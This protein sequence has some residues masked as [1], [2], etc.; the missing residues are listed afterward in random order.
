MNFEELEIRTASQY[1]DEFP[2]YPYEELYEDMQPFIYL[3][4]NEALMLR[5]ERGFI[6]ERYEGVERYVND[7]YLYKGPGTYI[8]RVEESVSKRLN[9][10]TNLPENGIVI[11]AKRALVDATGKRRVAGERVIHHIIIILY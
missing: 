3:K 10:L 2:L 6:D 11:K 1:P 5:A 7:E 8:P 4:D 9:A